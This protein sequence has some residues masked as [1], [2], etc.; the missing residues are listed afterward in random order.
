[1][2]KILSLALALLM[3]VLPLAGMAESA[4]LIDSGFASKYL[5]EGQQSVT[6]LSIEPGIFLLANL[7]EEATQPV[8]DLLNA[9]KI[10]IASQSSEIGG[11]GS[12]RL[13]LNDTNVAD[14]T[15]ALAEDGLYA[16]SNFLGGKIVK[17]TTE[18]L[19][20]LSEQMM[21]QM[22]EQGQ[23]TQEQL[24]SLKESIA[25][26]QQDPQ[27]AIASMFGNVDAGPLMAAA[28]EL[29]EMG[30]PEEVTEIPE[31]V[32]IEAKYVMN[33]TV[34]KDA[35]KNVTTE[36][37]KLAWS[38]PI[39]QQIASAANSDEPLTEESL[40]AKLNSVADA[41]AEDIQAKVYMNEDQSAYFI[42]APVEL[43][44]GSLLLR[45]EVANT[46]DKV[47]VAWIVAV[48]D[49]EKNQ[50][51]IVTGSED[52]TTTENG[53]LLTYALSVNVDEDGN[54]DNMYEAQNILMNVS[55][56]SQE[57]VKHTTVEYTMTIKQN[58]EAEPFTLLFTLQN[59]EKDLGDHAEDASVIAISVGSGE[60]I[61][62]VCKLNVNTKTTQAE[63]YIISDDATE[64]MSLSEE[65]MN[66]F[67]QEITPS[68]MGGL[69][70]LIQNLPESVQPFV[71]QL[72]GSMMQ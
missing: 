30:A 49:S 16:T 2:K 36:L 66:A 47:H 48:V 13:L 8:T 58:A 20:Q 45:C 69:F 63:A 42:D 53:G 28:S 11:Q 5:Q 7:P 65:E 25:S 56:T 51:V 22:V 21:Q 37:A 1:M 29:V 62:D 35:L 54:V 40:T 34:K 4:A 23:I 55:W 31:E 64:I 24:D 61:Y 43:N 46:E 14:I 71:N 9:L 15:V 44:K 38:M 26:F 19:N 59:E 57:S 52:V 17:L 33:V 50:N 6:D 12:L 72:M 32:T 67:T 68:L 70:G 41:L 18:Q 10:E 27:A 3:L 60:E 39:V